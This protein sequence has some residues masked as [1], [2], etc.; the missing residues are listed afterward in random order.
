MCDVLSIC[1]DRTLCIRRV[2]EA[3]ATPLHL[4]NVV[5]SLIV[6]VQK[7]QSAI[8][9]GQSLTGLRI[10]STY[11]DSFFLIWRCLL[12]TCIYSPLILVL[13]KESRHTLRE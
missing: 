2:I 9:N 4:F 6:D 1:P 10:Y 5:E 3:L 11:M 12:N 8:N 7:S 13:C